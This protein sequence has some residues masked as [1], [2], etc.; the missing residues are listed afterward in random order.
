MNSLNVCKNPQI[1]IDNAHIK[2]ND[3]CILCKYCDTYAMQN[4]GYHSIL[5]VYWKAL[6]YTGWKL[7]IA[8]ILVTNRIT[9]LVYLSTQKYY[10]DITLIEK[11]ANLSSLR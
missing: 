4:Y 11:L 10:I 5:V 6:I 2:H 7:I 9:K 8:G 3:V 1:Y